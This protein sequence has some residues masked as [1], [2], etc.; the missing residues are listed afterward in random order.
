MLGG[1]S[2]LGVLRERARRSGNERALTDAAT[3]AWLSHV[4]L[5]DEIDRV[6]AAL[7]A[8]GISPGN[9][10]VVASPVPYLSALLYLALGAHVTV[11]P[12]P[13]RATEAECRAA[14]EGIDPVAM[15]AT[16]PGMA[17]VSAA[18][19]LGIPAFEAEHVAGEGIT[20]RSLP[21]AS[22]PVSGGRKMASP[23]LLLTTSGTTGRP[24]MVALDPARLVAGAAK[25]AQTLAL[26]HTD[27]SV[28]IMPLHHIHGLVAGLLAPVLFGGGNIVRPDAEPEGFLAT[29]AAF[30]A[31]WYTAVPTMHH[32]IL[33]AARADPDKAGACRFRLIRSSS[34]ALPGSVR[35]GLVD[36]FGCPV[37]EAYGMTEATHQIACQRP[38]EAAAHG[39]VGMA[40]TGTL[41][42]VDPDGT[43]VEVGVQGEVLIR[44][45]NVIDGYL[46]NPEANETAFA[47][48]W[49][50]TGDIGRLNVDGSLT[51]VARSKE[52]VKRGGAQ[53]APTEVEEALQALPGVVEAIAFGVSHPTL[54]QDLAAAVVLDPGS[55]ADAR[56]LRAALLGRLS[57]HKVPS[58]ILAL[59][60][61]PK[62]PTGKP[63]RLE[64][65]ALLADDLDPG[66]AAP[67]S[68]VEGFLAALF[69]EAIG[70]ERIGR[71]DDFFLS[72]GDSLSGTSMM[73]HLNALVGT[74]ISGE[75]LFHYPTPAE[76]AAYVETL[77]N[78]RV[79]DL[80][81]VVATEAG[82]EAASQQ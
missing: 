40:E 21:G 9:V 4:A 16:D 35:S 30:G 74:T 37:V 10:I 65:E 27:S 77:D 80:L 81:A 57:D 45:A 17:H 42:I 61:I 20:L 33:R 55:G 43:E 22:R 1:Q 5:C 69:A 32:A 31:T 25:V 60:E 7:G 36:A 82:S 41:R 14:L 68:P 34:S 73:V 58:R 38:G 8:R 53:V 51:L 39:T 63:R 76:L 12:M 56:L 54:G 24:K 2:P 28:T 13:A 49:M 67:E 62:G 79:K 66:F 78:G 59:R 72:G 48:G 29:A 3:G 50:R 52:M 44:G 47:D 26:G 23:G 75:T 64:M 11:A 6:G 46:D 70:A 18:S 19:A 15:I 71:D